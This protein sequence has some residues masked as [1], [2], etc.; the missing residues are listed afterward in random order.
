MR[1]SLLCFLLA[2]CLL[3]CSFAEAPEKEDSRETAYRFPPEEIMFLTGIRNTRGQQGAAYS[4]CDLDGDEISELFVRRDG[5]G[6]LTVYKYDPSTD[7]AAVDDTLT[8]DKVEIFLKDLE[9]NGH[10]LLWVDDRQW[11][12]SS[13]IGV[14]K[15][16]GDPGARNDY[17]LSAGY[18]WL[19]EEHI[20]H[21]GETAA[22]I[23]DPDHIVEQK[24]RKC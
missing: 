24:K 5:E 8:G 17:Y 22:P 23:D 1:R 20:A 7:S 6:S 16:V 9:E 2:A 11:V 4:L 14:A 19:S 3:S 12:D 21:E 15:T 18:D 10:R 13:I